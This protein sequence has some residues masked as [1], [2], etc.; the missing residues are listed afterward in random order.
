MDNE[1]IESIKTT[2]TDLS[3]GGIEPSEEQLRCLLSGNLE[4]PFHFVNLL[5]FKVAACYPADHELAHHQLSGVEAYDKYGAVA[6]EQVTKRGGR[7]ITL[8][9]VEQ[10]IIGSSR[11][12]HRVATMEYKNINAFIDMCVDPEYQAMLVHREAGLE[13]T[14]VFV[15]RPLLTAAIE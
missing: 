5:A 11:V 14:E 9:N 4:G 2:L 7:L 3:H 15:T 13:A 8:N 12:W 1:E 10:Q 6:L